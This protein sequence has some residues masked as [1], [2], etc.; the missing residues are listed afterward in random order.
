MEKGPESGAGEE[1]YQ[2]YLEISQ[3]HREQEQQPDSGYRKTSPCAQQEEFQEGRLSLPGMEHGQ[4]S[5]GKKHIYLI[6]HSY[7]LPFQTAVFLS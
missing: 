6:L 4:V 2:L 5:T 3:G 1:P 7:T